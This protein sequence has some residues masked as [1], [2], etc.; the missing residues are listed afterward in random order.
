MLPQIVPGHLGAVVG[1][2]DDL[3]PVLD[4]EEVARRLAD[5]GAVGQEVD[6]AVP[7]LRL[8]LEG[9]EDGALELPPRGRAGIAD[10]EE[11]PAL[12]ARERGQRGGG[13]GRDGDHDPP[14][15][16]ERR[17]G[18]T[19]RDRER[20]DLGP[21]DVR[22]REL[23]GAARARAGG[24]VEAEQRG[25]VWRRA[26]QEEDGGGGGDREEEEEELGGVLGRPRREVEVL[27]ERPR[28]PAVRPRRAARGR[29][30]LLVL[31]R[32]GG[33]GGRVRGHAVLDEHLASASGG[34]EWSGSGGERVRGVVCCWY[35][36]GDFGGKARDLGW[37]AWLGRDGGCGGRRQTA[38]RRRA[39]DRCRGAVGRRDRGPR[40]G[41]EGGVRGAGARVC[42]GRGRGSGVCVTP[43]KRGVLPDCQWVEWSGA[44]W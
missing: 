22:V 31:A 29:G 40:G 10:G 44:G 30:R 35:R 28:V 37:L 15:G 43:E 18:A 19:G 13:R 11:L 24:A 32:G 21:G 42:V 1:V 17:E 33:G 9:E 27:G 7:E 5:V 39:G 41:S 38:R 12:D 25:G 8:Q 26:A 3:G 16:P 36:L 20:R 14:L 6:G 23:G 34:A 4:G 2:E